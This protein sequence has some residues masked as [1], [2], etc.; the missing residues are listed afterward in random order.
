MTTPVDA[1]Q[2][3]EGPVESKMHRLRIGDVVEWLD[4]S[5]FPPTHYEGPIM[6]FANDEGSYI[7]CH[8]TS[9]QGVTFIQELTEDEVHRVS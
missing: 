9:E 2:L 7:E 8:F 5:T 6:A 3:K 4:N 1:P